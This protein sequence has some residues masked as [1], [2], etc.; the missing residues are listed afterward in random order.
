[1]KCENCG[2]PTR[3]GC[4]GHEPV[5]KEDCN[6]TKHE[7]CDENC[8]ANYATVHDIHLHTPRRKAA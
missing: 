8:A 1:M 3:P 6:G 4:T 2:G 7:F 5:T